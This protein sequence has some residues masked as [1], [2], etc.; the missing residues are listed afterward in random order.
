MNNQKSKIKRALKGMVVSDKMDKTIVVKVERLKKHPRYLKYFKVSKRFKVR[1][2]NNSFKT[3]D[4]VTIQQCRP[5]SKTIR[6]EVV[7]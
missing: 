6:W 5:L 1:D 4:K 7:K 3:G 2:K